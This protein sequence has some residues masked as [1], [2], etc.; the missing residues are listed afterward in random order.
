MPEKLESQIQFIL[1][2][3][4][5]KAVLR[6][7]KPLGLNRY[8]NSAEHSWQVSML[9]LTL[10]EYAS[11]PIDISKVIKLLLLHD[12]VEIDVGDTILY[13]LED[14]KSIRESESVAVT[15]IFGLLPEDQRQQF[16]SLWHEYE[17]NQS[18]E[19]RFAHAMDRL[20]PVLQNLFNDGQSWL[21]NGIS[22]EQVL[23]KNLK[24]AEGAPVVW[25][26][27]KEKINIAAQRGLLR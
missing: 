9:A 26:Y 3:E 15:R 10:S 6:K 12:I 24:I 22:K 16:L 1:E 11:E 19:S 2:L 23:G 27:L 18:A 8:E 5:L 21:E 13:A 4:K 20:M 17:E 25:Q 7:T 14:S